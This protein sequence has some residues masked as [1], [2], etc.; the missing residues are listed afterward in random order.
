MTAVAAH[1]S[2]RPGLKTS[3]RSGV[4]AAAAR[5]ASPNPPSGEPW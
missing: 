1:S 3:G 5:T 4:R 2:L